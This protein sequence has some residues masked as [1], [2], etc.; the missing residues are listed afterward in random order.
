MSSYF[1]ARIYLLPHILAL[2]ATAFNLNNMKL[3]EK[4]RQA[5]IEEEIRQANEIKD[6]LAQLT[7]HIAAKAGA[8]GRLFGSVTT[9]EIADALNEQ[10]HIDI[11]KS[12]LVLK[13]AIKS[14]G[15]YQLKV[16]LGHDI[17]GTVSVLVSEA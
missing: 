9:K 15:S 3:Q 4:A 12:K 13:D 6:Q 14:C 16:K 11:N 10:H 1:K 7:V 17:T 5:Q 8:E 2:L